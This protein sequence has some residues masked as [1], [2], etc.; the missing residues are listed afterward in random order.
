MAGAALSSASVRDA[1]GRVV[2]SV[3]P[4][5]AKFIAGRRSEIE[6][7]FARHGDGLILELESAA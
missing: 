4:I 3:A 2:V 6:A 1:G 5:H 7:A